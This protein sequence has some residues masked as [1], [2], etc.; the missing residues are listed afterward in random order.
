MP[1]MSGDIIFLALMF[2]FANDSA[3]KYLHNSALH[4]SRQIRWLKKLQPYGP[5]HIAHIPGKT[6]T[7]ADALL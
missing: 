1:S 2:T 3:L 6:N 5:L 4:S 7:A